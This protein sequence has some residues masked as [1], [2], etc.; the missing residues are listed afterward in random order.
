[1]V[2]ETLGDQD[3]TGGKILAD[4]VDDGDDA[5]A[6]T[7][8]DANLASEATDVQKLAAMANVI[9]PGLEPMVLEL[10]DLFPDANN[11]VVITTEDGLPIS[12]ISEGEPTDSGIMDSHVTAAG[13]DVSG[14]EFYTFE[15][16]LTIY[17]DTDSLVQVTSEPV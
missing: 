12:L 3:E 15:G 14:H 6:T 10:D 17:F 8:E 9:D 2:A 13:I 5:L 4:L 16:G 11:E 1:M 7:G